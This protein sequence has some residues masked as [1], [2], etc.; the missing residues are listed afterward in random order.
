MST[1]KARNNKL[2]IQLATDGRYKIQKNG[3]V[4]KRSADGTYRAIGT[5]RHGYNVVTY[6]G[7][8]VV[9]ARAIAAKR[10]IDAGYTAESTLVNLSRVVV[11]RKNGTS[12]D[13]RQANLRN[14]YPTLVPREE[15][16]RLTQ[17]QKDRMVELFCEGFSVA[18]IARR[19]RR[20]ISRSHVSKVIKRE[21]GVEA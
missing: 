14:L 16:K 20:R 13:D 5:T 10:Y 6:K 21:L 4:K 12:L 18:K 15:T 17:K 9:V 7:K 19:F 11:H 2:A 8:K 3:T 1:S